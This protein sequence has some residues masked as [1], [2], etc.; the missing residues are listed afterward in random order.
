MLCRQHDSHIPRNGVQ[1]IT[2]L[3][4][5][6]AKLVYGA[7]NGPVLAEIPLA[8]KRVLDVGC[9]DG[10][11][12][13]H[14]KARQPVE[15]VGLTYSGGESLLARQILDQ[16]VV[17]D[18]NNFDPTELGQFDCIVCSHVLEH[19]LWP[20]RFLQSVRSVLAP[21]GRLVVGLPNLLV[22]RSRLRLLSGKFRY[23][24]GGIMDRTHFRFF[25]WQ[26]SR[27]LV[28]TAGFRIISAEAEGGF[29]LSRFLPGIGRILDRVAVRAAPGLFGH[30]FVIT[31]VG[32]S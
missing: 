15:V 31:A 10:T 26:T 12:G 2:Q 3:Q 27:E 9:G 8:A 21:G 28:T 22:F 17:C 23:T 20:D 1:I 16:V 14:L 7:L 25:D 6:D 4:L 24:D 11:L 13:R 29:P 5:T 18:L 19:L 32:N 30:Q